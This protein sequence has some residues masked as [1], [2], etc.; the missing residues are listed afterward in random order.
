MASCEVCGAATSPGSTLC[1][2]CAPALGG[3]EG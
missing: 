2:N 1:T 3:I